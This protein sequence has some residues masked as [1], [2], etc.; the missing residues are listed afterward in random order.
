MEL[1][2]IILDNSFTRIDG[3][4]QVTSY[5]N[6]KNRRKRLTII[7][8]I[9]GEKKEDFLGDW[10]VVSSCSTYTRYTISF[11]YAACIQIACNNKFL[12]K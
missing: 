4:E 5:E 2:S 12:L 8:F 7:Q 6:T 11:L 3:M 10:L 9:T 1:L